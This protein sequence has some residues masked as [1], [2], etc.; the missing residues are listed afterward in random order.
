MQT[1]P[2]A[3]RSALGSRLSDA[4]IRKLD[5]FVFVERAQAQ[6]FPPD[7]DVF[8]AL[9]LTPPDQVRAVIL[10]QDPY[11][12]PGQASGLAFSVR[13][14]VERPRS[15]INIVKELETDLGHPVPADAT[16]EPWARNGVLLLNTS[17]TVREGLPN[18][19]R[20]QWKGFTAAIVAMLAE[21][22]V[23]VAFLLWGE[24]AK[25]A[26]QKI[27]RSRH[28]VVKS[29]HPSPLSAKGFIGSAPFRRANSELTS[30]GLPPIDWDL[31]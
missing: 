23:P 30:R 26:G 17:L 6:V 14:G 24:H 19:H 12:R 2:A 29:A 22:P 25:A 7:E 27:D 3:W 4:D 18:S 21:R 1:L 15:L 20:R 11:Y 8:A 13:A 9:R 10:G 31:V 5:E 16:L 28:I